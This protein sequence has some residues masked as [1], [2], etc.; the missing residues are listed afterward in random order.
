MITISLKNKLILL[1]LILVLMQSSMSKS[2]TDFSFLIELRVTLHVDIYSQT[3]V[4]ILP[5]IQLHMFHTPVKVKYFLFFL[6][7][8]ITLLLLIL[9]FPLETY[10][11]VWKF[12]SSGSISNAI[13]SSNPNGKSL[14][15]S[16]MSLRNMALKI[17]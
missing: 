2:F 12:Y 8:P 16:H 15:L 7:V 9:L 13:S 10:V 6:H 17:N 14:L 3:W 5:H 4:L 11:Q 1:L